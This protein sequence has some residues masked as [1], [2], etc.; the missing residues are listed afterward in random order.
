M[1]Q[2]RLFTEF[3]A[4]RRLHKTTTIEY[5]YNYKFLCE[6]GNNL[7]QHSFINTHHHNLS[8]M[9]SDFVDHSYADKILFVV[10]IH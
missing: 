6:Q 2:S 7:C 4:W 10:E 3:L 8:K 9:H 5:R 1:V